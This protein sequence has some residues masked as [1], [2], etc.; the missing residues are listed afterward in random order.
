MLSVFYKASQSRYFWLAGA[1][2]LL[3]M[4]LIALY[5]QYVLDYYPCA[6]CVQIRAW[7]AG[8]IILSICS[9]FGRN[10]FWWRWAGLTLTT[11]LLGGALYT[12]WYAWGVEN[13]TIVSSCTMGAGFPEFMLL[14]QWIP[15][16]FSAEGICG[17]SPGMWF[18]LTMNEALLI[19]ISIP[20]LVLVAQWLLHLRYAFAAKT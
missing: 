13:G 7:V 12:S 17:R 19:T 16:L 4:E 3:T 9:Q 2:Y 20:L 11:L 6:L 1:L 18:G 15:W 14:D 8:A 10:Y 5:Y